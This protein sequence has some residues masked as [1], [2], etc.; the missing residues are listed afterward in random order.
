MIVVMIMARGLP[1]A[2][3]ARFA[4]ILA[5]PQRLKWN[6][7]P[8]MFFMPRVGVTVSMHG[9]IVKHRPNLASQS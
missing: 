1:A 7:E 6:V 3:S 8:P 9:S 2:P 4:K 5:Q